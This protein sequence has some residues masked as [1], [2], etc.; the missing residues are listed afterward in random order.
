MPFGPEGHAVW[1]LSIQAILTPLG[2]ASAAASIAWG[3]Q[4]RLVGLGRDLRAVTEEIRDASTEIRPGAIAQVGLQLRRSRLIQLGLLALYAGLLAQVVSSCWIGLGLVRRN[5][6]SLCANAAA[7]SFFFGI[8]A[9][10]IATALTL[11][12]TALSFR[13]AVHA[14][15]PDVSGDSS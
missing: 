8:V 14:A 9:L 15:K 11:V 13:V 6:G 2:I 7:A 3:L 5:D 12:D 1:V 4:D 10:L